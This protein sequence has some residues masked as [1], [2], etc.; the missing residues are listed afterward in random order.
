MFCNRLTSKNHNEAWT[1]IKNKSNVQQITI[2]LIKINSRQ[3]FSQRNISSLFTEMV[4]FLSPSSHI[5][6]LEREDPNMKHFQILLP[7]LSL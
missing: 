5:R 2:I 7:P 4:A 6:I 3:R 1:F